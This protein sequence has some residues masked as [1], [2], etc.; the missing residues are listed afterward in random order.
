M[1]MYIKTKK[2]SNE[3]MA[4][5]FCLNICYKSMGEREREGG[6]KGERERERE[7]ERETKVFGNLWPQ[8]E[9]N[10]RE[11]KSHLGKRPMDR[12][13][14]MISNSEELIIGQKITKQ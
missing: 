3:V 6:R 2:S 4:K 9:R 10:N 5:R 7:R 8:L 1:K 14:N 13:L 11:K 12:K